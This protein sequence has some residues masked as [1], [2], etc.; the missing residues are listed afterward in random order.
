MTGQI[1]NKYRLNANKIDE[2]HFIENKLGKSLT[3]YVYK[4]V[5][6]ITAHQLKRNLLKNS[7]FFLVN[8]S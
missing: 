2:M 7:L 4:I 5:Y 8:I 6:K 1:F 3:F